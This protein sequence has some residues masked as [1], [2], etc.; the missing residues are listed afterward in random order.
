MCRYTWA[1]Q[2]VG[3]DSL[4]I[5]G[6]DP[7]ATP[8]GKYYVGVLGASSDAAYTIT[9]SVASTLTTLQA[10][11][12][13]ALPPPCPMQRCDAARAGQLMGWSADGCSWLLVR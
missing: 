12:P 13:E 8:G 9:T 4:T 1:A 10:R 7:H 3:A 11:R 2:V 6:S 5:A